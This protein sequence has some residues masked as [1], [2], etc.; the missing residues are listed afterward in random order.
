MSFV[1]P[2]AW[3]P[4]GVTSL[5]GAAIRALRLSGDS[6]SVVASAGAGKTE[7]LAQKADFL[8]STGLCRAPQ[9]I[10]AI[11]FKSDAAK[12]LSDRVRQR[13]GFEFARRFDSQTFD[14]FSK[15]LIDRFGQLIAA[16]YTPSPNY[17]I[18][19]PK[20]R[21]FDDFLR[22]QGVY[23]VNASKFEQVLARVPLPIGEQKVPDKWK[24]LLQ[25]YWAES[26]SDTTNT[27]LSFPMINRLANYL[28]SSQ[29][30]IVT[31]LRTTYPYVFL[32]EFQDTTYGQFDLLKRAF[33]GSESYLT[34]VGDNKQRIM[35]WAGAMPNSFEVFEGD[36]AAKQETLVS[37]WRS[38]PELVEIQHAIASSLET[39]AVKPQARGKKS[40]D[41]D[42][43]AIWSYNDRGD[44][45]EGVAEWIANE[46]KGDVM[47]PEEC[48]ILV[49]FS[50]D[51]VERELAPVFAANGLQL[52]NVARNLGSI[53]IQDILAED[54]TLCVMA[55]IRLAA[56]PKSPD[57]WHFVT[58]HLSM[59]W[60]VVDTEENF[61]DTVSDDLEAFLPTLR[62]YLKKEPPSHSAAQ[63]AISMSLDFIGV[64]DLRASVP[65]YTRAM[66][67]QRARG[68][69]ELLLCESTDNQS[70]WTD[71]IDHF[72]GVGQV[73]LMSVHKSKG[74]EFHTMIFFGLDADTWW[75]FKPDD[76]E[77]MRAFFV[78]FT[79]AQQRAF[80]TS[81]SARGAQISYVDDLVAS[82][83]VA[84]VCGPS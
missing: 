64:K 53:A 33:K 48:A 68:G 52:R 5:E 1:K 32:D 40:V 24:G 35:V 49:R 34:A 23:D 19:F 11:S 39:D 69:L 63:S 54:I 8:L 66:D 31:A 12:N 17:Q 36:F 27:K 41:G 77:E 47:R 37:N 60:G 76:S 16:P 46:V 25:A 71:V 13:C 42:I 22:G 28:L 83:G 2:D 43:S 73:P 51:K 65:S 20:R 58:E 9:R 67:F 84:R 18:V 21:D 38:H 15:S 44:E 70:F 59:I 50:A 4:K 78:A 26:Y 56:R 79:R 62:A 80:F 57:D 45:C 75:S 55:L 29:P 14:A 6:V 3:E 72:D 10:L 74:L 7:F 61:N 82:A 81:C 30:K